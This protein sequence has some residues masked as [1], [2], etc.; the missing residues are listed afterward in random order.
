VLHVGSARETR[1]T[2]GGERPRHPYFSS[3]IPFERHI[4]KLLSAAFQRARAWSS[5]HSVRV[6]RWCRVGG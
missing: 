2:R 1:R 3:L 5:V 6:S 4:Q